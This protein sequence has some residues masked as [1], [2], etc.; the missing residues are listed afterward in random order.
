MSSPPIGNGLPW[1]SWAATVMT[2]VEKPSAGSSSGLAS[3]V[4]RLASASVC[5]AKTTVALWPM[6]SLLR[7]PVMTAVV[8]DDALCW[9][10]LY[11]LLS[12]QVIVHSWRDCV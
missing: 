4:E 10:V 3:M 12:G 5:A 8:G 1:L 6:A 11:I 2:A 7:V 9:M